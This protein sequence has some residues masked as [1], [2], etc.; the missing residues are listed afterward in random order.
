MEG[1][2]EIWHKDAF[3]GR[4]L[5]LIRNQVKSDIRTI[6]RV[7]LFFFV[8]MFACKDENVK[9]FN[10]QVYFT[11]YTKERPREEEKNETFPDS[12]GFICK[13]KLDT[14]I[15]LDCVCAC[16]LNCFPWWKLSSVSANSS[17]MMPRVSCKSS[18]WSFHLCYSFYEFEMQNFD[19][20]FHD[21]HA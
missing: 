13:E 14:Q 4:A 19:I 5:K 6:S 10:L 11:C 20:I 16:P 1:N 2:H 12:E 9:F 17:A 3:K 8:D 15:W 18:S 21:K 7:I